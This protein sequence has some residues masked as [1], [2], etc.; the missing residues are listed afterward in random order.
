M[1]VFT[2]YIQ[3]ATGVRFRIGFNEEEH[4]YTVNGL[5]VPCVSNIWTK[6]IK[7][8]EPIPEFVKPYLKK[9]TYVHKMT[10]LYNA[11]KLDEKTID[12]AAIGYFESLLKF[13]VDHKHRSVAREIRAYDPDNK[14][15][16]SVD[17]DALLGGIP[18]I[19]D[20]KTGGIYPDYKWK[21]AGYKTMLHNMSNNTQ[22]KDHRIAA[23]QLF[24]NGKA[25]KLIE[26]DYDE[27]KLGWDSLCYSYYIKIG[28]FN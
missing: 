17:D 13:K 12:E 3:P 18:Y 20:W 23:V 5:S 9:G 6:V 27:I 19:I 26:Y 8:D 21:I 24:E 4:L 10:E 14:I 11:G 1:E 25:G 2:D 22:Y 28:A 16:G 15:C 7:N